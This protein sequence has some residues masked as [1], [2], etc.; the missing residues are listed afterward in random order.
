MWM[1]GWSTLLSSSRFGKD[2]ISEGVRR[3]KEVPLRRSFLVGAS[4]DFLSRSSPIS[5]LSSSSESSYLPSPLSS[6]SSSP[7]LFPSPSSPLPFANGHHRCRSLCLPCHSQ[8]PLGLSLISDKLSSSSLSYQ[9]GGD[10]HS[11]PARWPDLSPVADPYL[12]NFEGFISIYNARQRA[13]F[14]D[15]YIYWDRRFSFQADERARCESSG[16]SWLVHF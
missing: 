12:Y 5:P 2:C 3:L 4:W 7:L 11:R 13:N 16:R 6:S 8:K 9:P 14:R 15:I 1:E 10:S